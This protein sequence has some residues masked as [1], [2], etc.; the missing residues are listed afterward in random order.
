MTAAYRQPL[1]GRARFQIRTV[2]GTRNAIMAATLK[3]DRGGA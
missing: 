2:G 3:R 1:A